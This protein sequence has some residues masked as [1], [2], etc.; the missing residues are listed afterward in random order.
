MIIYLTKNILNDK[1]YIGKDVKN[2]PNYLGSGKALKNA[3][4]KH[5]RENFQKYIITSAST[6]EELSKLEKYYIKYF[7]AVKSDM[8]YNITEGG[9]G[10]KTSEQ[11]HLKIAIYYFDLN[12]VLLGKFDSA[13]DAAKYLNLDRSKIVSACSTGKAVKSFL[14]SKTSIYSSNV[15]RNKIEAILQLDLQ[16]N[17]IKEWNYLQK[18]H[19]EGFNKANVL[20]VCKGITKS[21]YGFKWKYKN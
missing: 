1:C 13:G 14:F 10:G 2:N 17:F 4:R 12:K 15:K 9:E 5:G 7:N 3:I 6:K 16:D 8:Y 20:K 18:I 21:S 11:K 19:D